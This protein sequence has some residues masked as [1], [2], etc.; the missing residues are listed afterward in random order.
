MASDRPVL[1]V[2]DVADGGRDDP[3]Y[4]IELQL[5][6]ASV[7]SAAT[8]AGFVVDRVPAAQAGAP[9]LERRLAAADAVVV[10]GGEDVDP[11]FYGGRPDDPHRGQ[12]FPEADRAQ[13]ALVRRA[14]ETRTPLVGICRGMQLVNVALGGDLLQHLGGHVGRS[15]P[16]EH[17]SAM[18]EH[19]VALDP[20]SALARILGAVE[21]D[22]RSAHHQAVDRPGEGLVVVARA[23][24]GTVEALEHESAPLWCVQ[25]HPEE[26]G[27]RGTVLTDLLG[28]ALA[29]VR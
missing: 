8:A 7:V 9:E 14:V 23:D 1:L 26:A 15:V 29:A 13:I 16:G 4:E 22:V 19:R 17:L 5:L 28:A 18:V 24:D 6:T 27:S 10:T 25:W 21:L 3:E 20:A 2:V 11:Q 12:S